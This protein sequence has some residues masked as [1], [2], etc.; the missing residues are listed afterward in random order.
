VIYL[1]TCVS[2]S[3]VDEADADHPRALRLLERL[4]KERV[5]SRLTL[6]EL[7][8]VYSRAGLKEP[9]PLAVYSVRAVGARVVDLDFNEVLREA[10]VK[11]P[12]LKLRSL[13]LLHLVD[14]GIAGRSEVIS[15]ELGIRVVTAV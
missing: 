9:L 7:A 13:D 3:F 6:L 14:A 4:G 15:R 2:V 10:F 12:L 5:V 11:A 1:D 8:S